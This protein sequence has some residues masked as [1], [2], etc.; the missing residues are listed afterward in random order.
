MPGLSDVEMTPA[1]SRDSCGYSDLF[2][3]GCC[4]SGGTKRHVSS[5]LCVGE[6]LPNQLFVKEVSRGC[7]TEARL[8]AD[9]VHG[10]TAYKSI[11]QY[12]D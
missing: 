6:Y 10:I 12:G 7:C 1:G 3:S 4:C 11:S 8:G 5:L 2:G 9:T